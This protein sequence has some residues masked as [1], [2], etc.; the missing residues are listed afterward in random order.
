VRANAGV[1][2]ATRATGAKTGTETGGNDVSLRGRIR[3]KKDVSAGLLFV[4]AGIVT[5]VG[6]SDYPLGT[7]RSIGPGYFPIMIGVVLALLGAAVAFQG[8]SFGGAGNILTGQER[9]QAHEDDDGIAIRPLIMITLAVVAFGVTVR[10]LGLAIA[11]AALVTLS[12]L[13]GRTFELFRVVLLSVGLMAISWLIFIY[14]LGF[15]L[16]LW[17]R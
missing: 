6:A 3:N 8:L 9:A 11:T 13:A 15:P 2:D 4:A 16:T 1:F 5:V 12:S 10:P 7:M 14:F 17:P